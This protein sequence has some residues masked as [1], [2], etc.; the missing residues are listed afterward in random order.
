[1]KSFVYAAAVSLCASGSFAGGYVSTGGKPLAGVSQPSAQAWTGF[2][3]GLHYG[4]GSVTAALGSISRDTDMDAFGLHAGYQHDFGQYVLGLELDHNRLDGDVGESADLTRLRA[5]AGKGFGRV[6][7]YLTVGGAYY[8]EPG[9][10]DFGVTYGLGAE[11][12]VTDR[13][14]AG[15]EYTRQEVANVD[16]TG[17]DLTANILQARASF[18]F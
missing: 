18:R 16:G 10:S 14:V 1:M 15:L 13:F 7:P 3:A 12:L 9:Y 17:V 8:T 6:L 11:V 4:S 2:Y 5:R